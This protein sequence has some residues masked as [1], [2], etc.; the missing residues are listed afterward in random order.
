[1]EKKKKKWPKRL[2]GRKPPPKGKIA[3][4]AEEQAV[5]RGLT[6]FSEIIVIAA[7]SYSP[8][9]LANYLFDLAKKFNNFYAHHRI[10][11]SERG[12]EGL[13]LALTAGVAQVLKNGLT[14]L[15]IETPQRM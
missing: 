10:L 15:G 5:L 1:M 6:R 11:G 7:K 3:L 8:N 14:I 13:R 2:K 9:L 12:E 4:N